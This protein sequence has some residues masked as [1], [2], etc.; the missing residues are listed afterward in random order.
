M[1]RCQFLKNL[2]LTLE[3]K[4]NSPYGLNDI[5][6]KDGLGILSQ[7][8]SIC[9]Q[10]SQVFVG[11]M[12][13]S[14]TMLTKEIGTI[15]KELGDMPNVSIG[16]MY[17]VRQEKIKMKRNKSE[18]RKIIRNDMC[19]LETCGHRL[20]CSCNDCFKRQSGATKVSSMTVFSSNGKRRNTLNFHR[21]CCLIAMRRLGIN[22][23]S[24]GKQR[25]LEDIPVV[26]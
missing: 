26:T 14:E 13:E 25:T 12:M 9:Q 24:L 23:P 6:I 5:Y 20:D 1:S 17:K 2:G 19:R 10:C 4:C 7:E 22:I 16:D 3:K 21:S 11:N 15:S 18:L 8:T